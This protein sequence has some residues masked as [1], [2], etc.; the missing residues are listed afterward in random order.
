M[1]TSWTHKKNEEERNTLLIFILTVLNNTERSK[2]KSEKM[3]HEENPSSDT[4]KTKADSTSSTSDM[5]DC[6]S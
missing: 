6:S 4:I 2:R 5:R 3:V 1:G